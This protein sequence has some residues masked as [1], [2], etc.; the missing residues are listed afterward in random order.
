MR[1]ER[2]HESLSVPFSGPHRAEHRADQPSLIPLEVEGENV[3]AVT[4]RKSSVLE[5]DPE[6]LVALTGRVVDVESGLGVE[7]L[8]LSFL[9]S[10]PRTVV[11]VTGADGEYRTECVLACGVLT[12]MHLPDPADARFQARWTVEPAQFLLPAEGD[13]ALRRM[14]LGVRAP[15]RVLEVAIERADGGS[16]AA[17][18]VSLVWGARSRTGGFDVLG[19]DFELAD[20]SGCARFALPG[21]PPEGRLF[22]LEAELGGLEVSDLS[23]FVA[24]LAP[25][26]RRLEL[27]SG[28][29]LRVRCTN[30]RGEG[31]PGVSLWLAS[32][33]PLRAP[34]GRAG[35]TDAAGE[36]AFAPL[37]SGCWSVRAVHPLTGESLLRECDLARGA[38]RTL[39]LRLSL[40][41]LQSGLAGIV[42][43]EHE[44][45]LEGVALRV[46]NGNGALVTIE[47]RAGGR[48]EYWGQPSAGIELDAGPGFLDDEFV[49]A[50]L[51]LPF[52][53]GGLVLRRAAHDEPLSY[54][55]EVVARGSRARLHGARLALWTDEPLHSEQAFSAPN[56]V[57][58]IAVPRRGR[59]HYSAEAP[60]YRRARGELAERVQGRTGSVLAIELERGFERELVLRDRVTQR[61]LAGVR[62]RLG[63]QL[64]ATSDE[65]GRVHLVLQ[66][67]PA[68]LK[69]EG[70]GY[71]ARV[72]SAWRRGLRRRVAPR[73]AQSALSASDL[74][75]SRST[76]VAY[77]PLGKSNATHRPSGSASSAIPAG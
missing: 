34:R 71:A 35:D 22:E 23:A 57:T 74:V 62:I 43:D 37:S 18:N 20:G 10:R 27:Y 47:S 15:A 51:E 66:E 64:L 70:S 61:E 3:Q 32:S 56:G 73:A 52:G 44:Q 21:D 77:E 60:G 50:H 75:N 16:A 24:P 55:L 13:G 6:T 7:G 53:T 63:G 12:V 72:G 17:S 40:A 28:G 54:A 4:A 49:P 38:E 36:C 33:D 65:R 42:L 59:V 41:N 39:V 69:L 9:S 29:T 11:V 25:R 14:D 31:L 30:E 46:R 58:Q 8:R 5:A 1:R 2:E 26:P 68:L 48:F 19:R 45:P 67:W 76:T